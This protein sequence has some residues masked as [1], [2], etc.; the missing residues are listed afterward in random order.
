ML[1]EKIDKLARDTISKKLIFEAIFS[2]RSWV[3]WGEDH[4]GSIGCSLCWIKVN[5]CNGRCT[6]EHISWDYYFL[7]LLL[8]INNKITLLLNFLL[9]MI[10]SPYQSSPQPL[11]TGIPSNSLA[12]LTRSSTVVLNMCL[13]HLRWETTIFFYN[14]CYPHIL[15]NA[16]IFNP[17]LDLFG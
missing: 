6:W 1:N 4:S 9:I 11:G 10:F 8:E 7:L 12:L 16:Y 2:H 5:L 3:S 15:S 17:I 14:K 13:N